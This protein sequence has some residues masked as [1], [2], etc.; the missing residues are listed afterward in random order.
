MRPGRKESS[1]RKLKNDGRVERKVMR[2]FSRSCPEK[3]SAGNAE[4]GMG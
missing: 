3:N 4:A 1:R 2:I